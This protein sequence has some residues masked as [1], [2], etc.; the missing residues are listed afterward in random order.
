MRSPRRWSLPVAVSALALVGA[1]TATGASAADDTAWH[2]TGEARTLLYHVTQATLLATAGDELQYRATVN[3]K[4]VI[5]ASVIE[6]THVRLGATIL[7]VTASFDGPG[8]HRTLD[9]NTA[10]VEELS[11]PL[12]GHLAQ[13]AGR[14]HFVID[15]DP[16][17][18]VVAQVAG[19]ET[20]ASAIAAAEP[21]AF[22][23]G[24]PSPLAAGAAAAY[25][26]QA[27]SALWTALLARPS[28]QP[29]IVPLLPPLGGTLRRVWQ[30]PQWTLEPT[31][32]ANALPIH[33]GSGPLAVTG[34][35][36]ALTGH[37]SVSPRLGMPSQAEGTIDT[38]VQLT[39]LTQPVTETQ[40]LTWRLEEAP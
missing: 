18:G 5:A 22:G 7:A 37:G 33:L 34:T 6:P 8:T 23:P 17:T 28:A 30:G 4:I 31:A 38:T 10:T 35:I 13:L 21:S 36:T 26:S 32:G 27:L 25:S 24:Q 15:C 40:H 9:T 2:F 12:L 14:P 20:V 3:W 11:D 16:R 19:G 29:Q 39:A 1:G